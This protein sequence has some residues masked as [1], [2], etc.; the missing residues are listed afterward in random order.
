MNP[1]EDPFVD[2]DEHPRVDE[3]DP[4]DKQPKLSTL[5]PIRVEPEIFVDVGWKC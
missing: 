2:D 3:E 5:P 4:R 1:P